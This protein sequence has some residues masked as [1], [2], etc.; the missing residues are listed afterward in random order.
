MHQDQCSIREGWIKP[1][2][3]SVEM[4][5]PYLI[6]TILPDK[7][8]DIYSIEYKPKNNVDIL[9][10]SPWGIKQ[11]GTL[12]HPGTS[13]EKW[14]D[15]Y[16]G[17]WQLMF[18][19]AGEA[20]TYKG[21]SQGYHGEAS[22]SSWDYQTEAEADSHS[23]TVIFTVHLSRTPFRLVR[24]VTLRADKAE[25]HIHERITN[26]SEEGMDFIWGQ[27]IA[28]GAPFL[29]ET[30]TLHVPNDR[31]KSDYHSGGPHN[32]LLSEETTDWPNAQTVSGEVVDFS[33]IPPK[34]R[35]AVDMAYL[36]GLKEGWY[37]LSNKSMGLNVGVAWDI[38]AFPFVW[39]WQEFRGSFGYPFYGQCYVLGIEPCSSPTAKGLVES[40]EKGFSSMLHPG[41][42]KET[43]LTMVLFEGED[44]RW[45]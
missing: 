22:C 40:I 25:I 6:V 17:G 23:V 8:A 26:C 34:D 31:M 10:K 1:G 37:V 38:A 35:R 33:K 39:L 41:E 13:E 44:P 9:W 45:V 3:R 24:K 12:L 16:P 20:C 42:S 32:R 29:D 27:H 28:F 5:N 36:T 18:P 7:G 11:S 4:E 19:N 14:L 2:I 43:E 30:C 21:A 15:Y